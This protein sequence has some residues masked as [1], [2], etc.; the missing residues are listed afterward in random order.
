VKRTAII[1]VWLASLAAAYLAGLA[2]AGRPES[3]QGSATPSAAGTALPAPV[4]SPIRT[5]PAAQDTGGTADPL[6]RAD[7]LVAEGRPYEALDVLDEFFQS[8]HPEATERFSRALFLLSD[9][10][11]M[12]GEVERALSPLFDILR[13]PATPAI[14]ERARRRLNLLINAREQQLINAGDLVGLVAYFQLLVRE[15]PSFDGHRLKLARWLLRSGDVSA[16]ARLARE[17]GLVG[18][19]EAEIESLESEIRLAGTALPV[20]REGGAMYASAVAAGQQRQAEFRFLIDTGATMTGLAE[21]R[22]KTLG[23]VLIDEGIRVQTANGVVEL[24]VYRLRE[25]RIGGLLLEDLVVLGFAD[26][27]RRADGLLGM[28]VLG[29]LSSS[30]PGAVGRP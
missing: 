8:T 2:G 27:P 16:A 14:A 18:V 7:A 26:L 1:A 10:R 9:L 6:T 11:Q 22:L 21:S 30:M 12:T 4:R 28:D 20:E 29:K 25:L 13:Y 19:T 15:E 23:A 5:A 17:I 3:G 24:P